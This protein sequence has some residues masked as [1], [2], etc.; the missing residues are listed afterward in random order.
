MRKVLFL[1]TGGLLFVAGYIFYLRPEPPLSAPTQ[2]TQPPATHSATSKYFYPISKFDQRISVKSFGQYVTPADAQ[3]LPCGA[4]FTGYHTGD[5]LEVFPNELEIPVPVYAIS[6]GK[7][8]YAG[9]VSGYGG[10]VIERT[11]IDSQE[12]TALYG[13]INI[14]SL[15]VNKGSAVSAGQKLAVLGN[16]CS[17]QTDYERKHLHFAIHK[18]AGINFRG[19]VNSPAEL[20]AWFNPAEV[21]R[22]NHAQ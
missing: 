3:K 22:L 18:G 6:D 16:A 10:V 20:S 9:T 2:V 17:S 11:N 7:I 21:L 12:V 13:H 14:N 19:Y 5:D 8:V 1:L 15:S 4:P